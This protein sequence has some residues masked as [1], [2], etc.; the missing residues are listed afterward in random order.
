MFGGPEVRHGLDL[1]LVHCQGGGDEAFSISCGTAPPDDGALGQ[2]A[3]HALDDLDGCGHGVALVGGVVG[4][5]DPL[6][7]VDEDRF[8]GRGAGVHAEPAAPLRLFDARF[9]D[10]FLCVAGAELFAFGLSGEKGTHSRG[11][12][13]D[14]G[15]GESLDEFGDEPG[16]L[17]PVFRVG[18]GEGA[19]LLTFSEEGGA[20]RDVEL[21]VLGSDESLGLREEF[22]V[23]AAQ[24]GQE[25]E[26]A[27][28]E[29]DGAAN[30][31]PAGEAG[32]G[33]GGDRREDRGCEVLVGGPLVDEGLDV[34]FREDAAA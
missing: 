18:G 6:L 33:L 12:C 10:C 11:F 4:E 17:A 20:D 2:F 31:A 9:G 5:D 1:A 26:G 7:F 14:G 19:A 16:V 15:G 24:F 25:V 32:N 8:D 3:A 29:H 21:R 28:E 27:A 30:G 13:G 22:F 23:G 34:G